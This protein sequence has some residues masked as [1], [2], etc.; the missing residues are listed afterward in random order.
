MKKLEIIII[1]YNTRELTMNCINSIIETSDCSNITVVDNNSSDDT[2]EKVQKK[3]P[4]VKI[5][6]NE[7]NIG[8]GAAINVAMKE[9][10]N[11]YIM[12]SNS[13][14]IF[15]DNTINRLYSELKSNSKLG[16]IG[17]QQK[18]PDGSWQYSSGDFPGIKNILKEIFL[19]SGFQRKYL[20]IRFKS[21]NR[22][23]C[24]KNVEYVD[25]A[26][27][28]FRTD[29]FNKLNGFDEDF[30]FYSEEAD[31]SYRLKKAGYMRIIIPDVFITHLRGG[32]TVLEKQINSLVLLNKGK[33]LFVKKHYS[34]F[35][36]KIFKFLLYVH[37][38]EQVI[39]KFPLSLFGNKNNYY[40]SN[41]K[42][43]NKINA[44]QNT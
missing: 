25:G 34:N 16:V 44:L 5:I 30:F 33:L 41:L 40:L 12:V 39:I 28:A 42:A 15:H 29:V 1:S 17:C 32:T 7:K 43:L 24:P 13:D 8:Y 20:Q 3:Y 19:I 22:N 36:Y 2:I 35:S 11:D 38:L 14:V 9:S 6:K 21:K 27:L 4:F 31:F 37:A 18:Y 26:L 10:N 23:N